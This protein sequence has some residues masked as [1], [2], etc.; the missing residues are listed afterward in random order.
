MYFP[1]LLVSIVVALCVMSSPIL[2]PPAG[3]C[4]P[5]LGLSL[6]V[7][8]IGI[9]YAGHLLSFQESGILIHARQR[10]PVW[11]GPSKNPRHWV[12]NELLC[13][14]YFA[15]VGSACCWRRWPVLWLLGAH[16]CKLV[17]GFPWAL[18]HTPVPFADIASYP[19]TVINRSCEWDCVLSP[20]SPANDHLTGG[21]LR[22][23]NTPTVAFHWLGV[24][25]ESAQGLKRLICCFK[26][27]PLS[28]TPLS[29]VSFPDF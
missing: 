29:V 21:G 6:T 18:P 25:Q 20:V 5:Y 24:V 22:C 12:S 28:E 9:V 7:T 13:S 26:G 15:R 23:P 10:V 11:P 16:P 2:P 8:F 27:S 17:L 4:F 3:L 19:S 14:Q 1:S